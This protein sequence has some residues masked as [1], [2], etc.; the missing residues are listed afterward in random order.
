MSAAEESSLQVVETETKELSA[1]PYAGM[2][3]DQRF[4]ALVA[5][6]TGSPIT[7]DTTPEEFRHKIM[8]VEAKMMLGAARGEF[9]EADF[10]LEHEFTPDTYVR[11]IHIPA[12]SFVVGKLHR[13]KHVNFIS[14]GKV[15]VVT[16]WG[17]E[18]Y[19]AP[20]RLISEAGTK[21]LLYIHEDLEWTSVHVTPERDLSVIE[22]QVIAKR[23][24][25]IGLPNPVIDFKKLEGS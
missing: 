22:E 9:V 13:H 5:R 12:G 3:Q 10:P 24:S 1:T 18:V 21:R 11:T 7:P 15:S 20:C 19:T 14:K 4:M 25:D 2:D 16:E 6:L 17:H 8:L 23:Y